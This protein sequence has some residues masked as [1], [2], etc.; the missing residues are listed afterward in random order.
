MSM[1]FLNL[2]AL[3]LS[4]DLLTINFYILK[5]DS[6]ILKVLEARCSIDLCNETT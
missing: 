3:L 5:S 4:I 2:L 6:L 1:R